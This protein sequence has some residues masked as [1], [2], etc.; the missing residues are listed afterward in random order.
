MRYFEGHRGEIMVAQ[1]RI[2][3]KINKYEGYFKDGIDDL[4]FN[5]M[6]RERK[7]SRMIP[8]YLTRATGVTR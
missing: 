7:T 5:W 4:V 2:E 3:K 6:Y 1:I 8:R